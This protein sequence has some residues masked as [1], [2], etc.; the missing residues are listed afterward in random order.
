MD[1]KKKHNWYKSVWEFV[2]RDAHGNVKER[3]ETENA[4]ADEGEQS[5]LDTYFRGLNTPTQFFLRLT[6]DTPVETDTLSNITGLVSGNGYSAQLLQRSVTGF[7]GLSLNAGDYQVTTKTVTFTAS[8]GSIPITGQAQYVFI[9]T[10]SNNTGKH[11]AFVA[12]S[13]GRKLAAGESLQITV[14]IKL[15]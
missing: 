14:K 6:K 12:L 11:I 1:K 7:P 3:W 15:Q 13:Q 5:M 2:Y 10:T 9:S 4:L 8:G